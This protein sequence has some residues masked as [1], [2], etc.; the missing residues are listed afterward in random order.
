MQTEAL[1]VKHIQD[2]LKDMIHQDYLHHV[3]T[4]M[5]PKFHQ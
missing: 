2:T 1:N 3:P 5:Q 4:S